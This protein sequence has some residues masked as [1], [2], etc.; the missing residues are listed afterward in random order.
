MIDIII[1]KKL[2][3]CNVD[4]ESMDPDITKETIDW[5]NKLKDKWPVDKKLIIWLYDRIPN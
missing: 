1:T 2:F 3:C 5:I 4:K